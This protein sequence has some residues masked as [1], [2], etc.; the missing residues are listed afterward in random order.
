VL[1]KHA[2]PNALIPTLTIMGLQFSFLIA[3]AVIV[4]SIFSLPGIGR[5]LFQ[6]TAQ[7]D[8]MV[9]RSVVLLLVATVVCV[10]LIVELLWALVDPRIRQNDPS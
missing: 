4:E 8:L 2:F 7:R 10:N 5:L 3:G 6:A 1:L 9:M